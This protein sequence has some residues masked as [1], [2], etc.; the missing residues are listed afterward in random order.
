M[1]IQSF[2]KSSA[3]ASTLAAILLAACPF[4]TG[5]A[6]AA[7]LT[8]DTTG[9]FNAGFFAALK[10]GTRPEKNC[11]GCLLRN[12][13]LGAIVGSLDCACLGGSASNCPTNTHRQPG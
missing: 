7:P 5:S 13:V 10:A 1:T 3:A 6:A 9:I 8:T 11:R 12:H 4:S 2:R